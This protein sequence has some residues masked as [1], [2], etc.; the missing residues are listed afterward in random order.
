MQQLGNEPPNRMIT[1]QQNNEASTLPLSSQ[2]SPSS[3]F[4]VISKHGSE[5][6]NRE[7]SGQPE[8]Y[9][10]KIE[11]LCVSPSL[12][13]D[14]SGLIDKPFY[15]TQFQWAAT[16]PASTVLASIGF[17][18]AIL[19]LNRIASAPFDLSSIYRMRGCVNLQVAGTPMHGGALIASVLSRQTVSSLNNNVLHTYQCAPHAFLHAN[20]TSAVCI[21]I[22]FYSPTRYRFTPSLTSGRDP[23]LIEPATTSNAGD[24]AQLKVRVLSALTT[25]T[26]GITSVVVTVSVIFKELEFYAPKAVNAQSFPAIP[27][28][29]L[30]LPNLTISDLILAA[31]VTSCAASCVCGM[32]SPL[33]EIQPQ[34]GVARSI[35]GVFDSL[36]TAGKAITSEGIDSVRGWVKKYTGLHNPNDRSIDKRV[37]LAPVN[38]P[39]VVD[40][41]TRYLPLDPY[42]TYN[43][44]VSPGM[45]ETDKDEGL[46]S[47]I[48]QKP[49]AVSRF[50]INTAQTAQTLLFSA[51]IS[52]FM[53]R[54]AGPPPG[55]PLVSA[56]I[57]KLAFLSRF[58]S[59]D[60]ELLI[61]HCGSSFHMFKLLVVSEYYASHEMLTTPPVFRQV[62]N[63]PSQI[64]EF[65][66]G[67]QIHS[68]SLPQNSIFD[69]IP[70]GGDSTTNAM[71]HGRLSIFLLQPLVTNGSVA[72][73]TDVVVH[74]RAKPN[75]QFYGYAADVLTTVPITP[76]LQ[77]VLY[78]DKSLAYN[79]VTEKPLM[80]Q[81]SFLVP[82]KTAR[83]GGEYML[84]ADTSSIIFEGDTQPLSSHQIGPSWVLKGTLHTVLKDGKP[85]AV[86]YL[87]KNRFIVVHSY[88]MNHTID[89]LTRRREGDYSLEDISKISFRPLIVGDT[90]S[91]FV[92][93]PNIP[94][95][96]LNPKYQ[97][98]TI[99]PQSQLGTPS[100]VI[101]PIPLLTLGDSKSHIPHDHIARPIVHIRDHLRRVY[102]LSS[103]I[104]TSGDIITTKGL[105][106]YSLG[107]I[108]NNSTIASTLSPFGVATSMFHGYRGGF[109]IQIQIIG[110]TRASVYYQPPGI[111]LD[112]QG[113]AGN[114]AYR[115]YGS[116]PFGWNAAVESLLQSR[117]TEIGSTYP[118]GRSPFPMLS[119]PQHSSSVTDSSKY[120][121]FGED[122]LHGEHCT[123]EFEIPYMNILRFVNLELANEDSYASSL[124][125]II[126]ALSP[127][128]ENGTNIPSAVKMNLYAG[129]SDSGAVCFQTTSLPLA[130]SAVDNNYT[131]GCNPGATQDNVATYNAVSAFYVG[132]PAT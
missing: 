35:T 85:A 16:S 3:D 49:M 38:N 24:F 78:Y 9:N 12:R 51:P 55:A 103:E 102:P 100:N 39:N 17:P 117:L 67:G 88:F 33:V 116:S 54:N 18:S 7:N 44:V 62:L 37:I 1:N 41:T 72:T 61:Q 46:I 59:G 50:N 45:W 69:L 90:I 68:V 118:H 70:I 101:D 65:S 42:A 48:I 109:K 93:P 6:V 121:N 107:Q 26:A 57:Q 128:T 95:I 125:N 123:F 98:Q 36:A 40:V 27:T 5:L 113:P 29:S 64:L 127:K 120:F 111:S 20:N 30:T 130:V 43:S 53:F 105:F 21:E 86:T 66:G 97:K 23:V 2:P 96:N 28:T 84:P 87:G 31:K 47:N 58:Y 13:M 81:A 104:H 80:T 63:N 76:N 112:W 10:N 25:P 115:Y 71:T 73:S 124:G 52:P 22:P 129:A 106:Y 122:H 11:K 4:D 114:G 131:D 91:M 119:V 75:F 126:I 34:S 8:I 79:L 60:L 110:T 89:G 99:S 32:C 14:Y 108:L 56:P 132:A 82:V 74:V 19:Q 77:K 83:I 15:L 94:G 92:F